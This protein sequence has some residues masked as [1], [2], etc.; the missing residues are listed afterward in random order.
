M[1]IK[2]REFVEIRGAA[3]GGSHLER[4]QQLE[5]QQTLVLA[6]LSEQN[7]LKKPTDRRSS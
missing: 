3:A 4:D 6:C 5:F 7:S 1:L 2:L